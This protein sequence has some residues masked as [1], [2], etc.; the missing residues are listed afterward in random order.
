MLRI[1]FEEQ[2]VYNE[3]HVYMYKAKGTKIAPVF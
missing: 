3:D 2:G 1:S